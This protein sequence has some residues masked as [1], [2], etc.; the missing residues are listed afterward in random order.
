M[1]LPPKSACHFFPLSGNYQVCAAEGVEGVFELYNLALSQIELS[2]PT[3][4]GPIISQIIEFTEHYKK[5]LPDTYTV[6]V[7]FTDGEIHDMQK[8]MNLIFKAAGLPLSV[9]IVGIGDQSF[10]KMRLLDTKRARW[11][12][13]AGN[14]I[15]RDT[16]QFILFRQFEGA[17][18]DSIGKEVLKRLPGQVTRYF[19]IQKRAP[20]PPFEERNDLKPEEVV[21][22]QNQGGVGFGAGGISGSLVQT[23]RRYGAVDRASLPFQRAPDYLIT[24]PN[25][26]NGYN[27]MDARELENRVSEHPQN[28]PSAPE[29]F[30]GHS[31]AQTFSHQAPQGAGMVVHQRTTY[32]PPG[33][34]NPLIAQATANQQVYYTP[35][36]AAYPGYAGYTPE[37]N[38][39]VQNMANRILVSGG[40]G[41]VHGTPQQPISNIMAQGYVYE[42]PMPQ[43]THKVERETPKV[44]NLNQNVKIDLKGIPGAENGDLE[45]GSS[46]D[47]DDSSDG[48]QQTDRDAIIDDPINP[49]PNYSPQKLQ[50]VQTE[51]ISAESPNNIQIVTP[52]PPN[53]KKETPG[54]RLEQ[55]VEK[56][57]SEG[58]GH[59]GEEGGP[60]SG[61][62]DVVGF[63]LKELAKSDEND[64]EDSD[65]ED[66]ML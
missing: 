59:V 58:Q 12:G 7:I 26:E 33:T 20:N 25:V 5:S 47:D 11:R 2:G 6:L 57:E 56:I 51:E 52:E 54:I 23:L 19:E 21:K 9:I 31:R 36:Q 61:S 3:Y 24:G 35:Q 45:P 4:F 42:T 13:P 50:V 66:V 16:S 34:Y 29:R 44:P 65:S 43:K 27:P 30:S 17:S 63:G 28:V 8:T 55:K 64:E 41:G 18:L 49:N 15:E 38:Q 32:F 40:G 46:D 37:T 10:G 14:D 1:Q 22:G 48:K 39:Y 53:M 60:V 62:Y